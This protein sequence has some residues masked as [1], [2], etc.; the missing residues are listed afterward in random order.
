MYNVYCRVESTLP[1]IIKQMN[2]YI[3]KEGEKI[4]MD[5]TNLKDPIKF[6]QCLLDFKKKMDDTIENSFKNDMKF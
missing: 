6:T 1:F 5:K 4:I 2:P 3:M